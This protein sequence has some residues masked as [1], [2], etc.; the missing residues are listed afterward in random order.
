M[1]MQVQGGPKTKAGKHN[2]SKNALKHGMTSTK[3]LC[4]E[5]QNRFDYLE[6]LLREEYGP[7]TITEELYISKIANLQIRLERVI[8]AE[9]A[10]IALTQKNI[11]DSTVVIDSLDIDMDTKKQYALNEMAGLYKDKS[12]DSMMQRG[13]RR[14][15]LTDITKL[16][17]QAPISSYK[18][19]QE[20]FLFLDTIFKVIALRER[21]SVSELF[22]TPYP[23]RNKIFSK[24][25]DMTF[26]SDEEQLE[27]S[28]QSDVVPSEIPAEQLQTFLE[29]LGH[30]LMTTNIADWIDTEIDNLKELH[31]Q[32]AMPEP[33]TMDRFMRYSTTL[34]NQ[35]SKA[36]GELRHIIKERKLSE[37]TI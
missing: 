9:Q 1:N 30:K 25:A 17:R 5:E 24:I 34:S 22:K 14:I 32:A 2:S 29:K 11:T 13:L 19:I 16:M 28:K 23:E 18:I 15:L 10:T 4:P 7:S 33:A 27:I 37:K 31:L 8:R 20:Q 26:F 3:L 6:K 21:K 36:I 35:L 12:D